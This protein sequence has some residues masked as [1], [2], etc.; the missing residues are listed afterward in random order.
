VLKHQLLSYAR[1]FPNVANQIHLGYKLGTKA[2][3]KDRLC[4]SQADTG[5]ILR[6]GRERRCERFGKAS[7]RY[8]RLGA[9]V[10]HIDRQWRKHLIH[11]LGLTIKLRK[12]AP[13]LAINRESL[14]M[15]WASGAMNT[16]PAL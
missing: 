15:F 13:R 5:S 9:L 4:V 6:F 2:L 7:R 16:R 3:G 14:G 1:P 8:R 12:P 11:L 10:F